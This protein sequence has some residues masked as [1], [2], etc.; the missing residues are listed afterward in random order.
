MEAMSLEER[1][2]RASEIRS[3]LAEID[4]DAAG[5]PLSDE[6]REEWNAL[7]EERE[8]NDKVI[9]ELQTR[10]ALLAELAEKPEAQER[11]AHFYTGVKRSERDIY[12]I[13]SYRSESRNPEH[14][15]QLLHDGAMRAVETSRFPDGDDAT[16]RGNVERLMERAEREE[17]TGEIAQRVL[18]TGSPVYRRAFGKMMKARF[19]INAAGLTSE[20]RT[21]MSLTSANG[22]YAIP[23]A[24]DPTV[25]HSSNFSVNPFRAISRVVPITG[26]NTWEG[27]SSGGI[28][29]SFDTE[30][31]E[32]SDDSPTFA[33]PSCTVRQARAFVR[34]STELEDDWAG[35]GGE[36]TRLFADAKDD[37]EGSV[38]T[39]GSG[40]APIPLGIL[41]TAN[42]SGVGTAAFYF[43]AGTAAFVIGDLYNLETAL[44]P[45]WRQRASFMANRAVYN[46]IR[47]FDTA[48]GAGLWVD[49]LRGGLPN[50][51]P[52]NGNLNTRLL[53]YPTNEN[54]Y[55]SSSPATTGQLTMVFGDFNQF[56]IVDR[57]G[58]SIEPV[59]Q[60]FNTSNNLPT[61][62]RGLL[63]R[64]RVG[65]TVAVSTA[66]RVLK[67]L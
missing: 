4:A 17:T 13:T 51:V 29:A 16:L 46:K 62:Q 20:E 40:T 31:S 48:G 67:V 39:T 3:R 12:D 54:S 15:V 1:I 26:A 22:G 65:S 43:T 28:T 60:L 30:A 21:A 41:E 11:G 64:W 56:V 52:T 38:F 53:D 8:Q 2:S 25:I 27:V 66:F 44:A 19:D 7:H 6:A 33:Q 55:M 61:T 36:M 10:K 9:E 24:L 5:A 14:H 59:M 18:K 45:R 58:M 42:T 57:V 34:F 50:N 32:V 49:N 63:A 35:L 47:Q 23:F 37:L